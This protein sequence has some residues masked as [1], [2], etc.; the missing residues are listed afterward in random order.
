M[1]ENNHILKA[2]SM[3]SKLLTLESLFKDMSSHLLPAKTQGV[4]ISTVFL[5]LS[6]TGCSLPHQ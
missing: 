5:I 6:S 2:K 4:M 1:S 3:L